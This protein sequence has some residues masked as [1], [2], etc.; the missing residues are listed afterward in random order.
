MPLVDVDAV[1]HI[2]ERCLFGARSGSR[3]R[4]LSEADF[5]GDKDI[6]ISEA[7]KTRIYESTEQS[8]QGKFS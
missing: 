6:P 1:E 5:I 3:L 4:D 7:I 2:T 8:F